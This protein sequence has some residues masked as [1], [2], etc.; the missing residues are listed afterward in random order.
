MYAYLLALSLAYPNY[1]PGTAAQIEAW[2]AGYEAKA[3]D[4]N[5]Y[6]RGT[7]QHETW[8]DARG[9]TGW[10]PDVRSLWETTL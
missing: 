8:K 6:L 1:P 5:P 10:M 4:V 9:H 7:W 3:G 2:N